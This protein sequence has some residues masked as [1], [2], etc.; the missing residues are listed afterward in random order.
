[1]LTAVPFLFT[2]IQ[3]TNALA[4]ETNTYSGGGMSSGLMSRKGCFSDSSALILLEGS[5]ANILSINSNAGSGITLK[6]NTA[7]LNGILFYH[8][9]KTTTGA[10]D[11]QKF[12]TWKI[13][14]LIVY[15]SSSSASFF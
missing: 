7:T 1:M 12:H 6:Q 2:H 10:T 5:K 15:G 13:L 11:R 14:P 3:K 9:N 8:S 4:G